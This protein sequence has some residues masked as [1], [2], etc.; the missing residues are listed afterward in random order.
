MGFVNGSM[1][2]IQNAGPGSNGPAFRSKKFDPAELSKVMSDTFANYDKWKNA[3][4]KS[5][6]RQGND[7][8][9]N[10]AVVPGSVKGM[11]PVPQADTTV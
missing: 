9:Q 1:G 7:G 3:E 11:M 5:L 6:S 10:S 4:Q 8:N 2:K